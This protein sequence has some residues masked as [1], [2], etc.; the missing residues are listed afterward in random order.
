[1]PYFSTVSFRALAVTVTLAFGLTAL[2]AATVATAAAQE[3]PRLTIE[4]TEGERGTP[5]SAVATGFADCPI[6]GN[7]DVGPSEVTFVWGE[8][9]NS[10]ELAEVAISSGSA[11]A[12]FVVPADADPGTHSV[13]ARC[14]GDPAMAAPAAFLVTSPPQ[15]TTVPDLLGLTIDEAA[16]RLKE[17][18]LVL[19]SVAGS[20]ERVVDQDPSSGTDALVQSPVDISV[21]VSEPDLV[22]VPNLIGLTLA[23]AQEALASAG[24]A[25]GNVSGEGD[26]VGE[27]SLPPDT[28]VPPG[29]TVDLTMQVDPPPTVLV[30]DLV[31]LTEQEALTELDRLRLRLVVSSSSDGTVVETQDPAPGTVV[32]IGSDVTVVTSASTSLLIIIPGLAAALLAVV[33]IAGGVLLI[34]RWY[35]AVQRAWVVKHVTANPVT[36]VHGSTIITA[37]GES[38]GTGPVVRI[39][40]HPGERHHRFEE[41]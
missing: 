25:A 1:M 17:A 24:L 9:G 27:Q 32:P 2:G 37:P 14:A 38:D 23:D 7:D 11:T 3:A 30:P 33:I 10:I 8:E 34:R 29:S 6:E 16:G 41:V 20:G 40:S 12:S 35:E 13:V 22:R 28:Q 4:P 18:D 36:P 19:G 39:E 26:R 31:G 21:G 15:T 5:V